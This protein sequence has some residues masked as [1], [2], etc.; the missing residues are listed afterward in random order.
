MSVYLDASILLR[1][2]LDQ[3]EQLEGWR[4]LE[5]G[6]A[7]ALTEV[8]SLRTLDRL[9][10]TTDLDET[11]LA[12]RRRLV[13]ALTEEMELVEVSRPILDRAAGAFPV[14]VGTL[15]A[16]HLS[17]ALAWQE[18][19]QEDITFATHDRRLASAAR[20]VGLEVVGA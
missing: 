19:R 8:E 12:E 20:A 7:S 14:T 15:D 5:T 9:R 18:A 17:T 13:Y 1:V 6:V 16:I 11:G 10:L 4:K 3:P 2:V